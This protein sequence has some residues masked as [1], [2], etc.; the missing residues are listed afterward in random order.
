[1]SLLEKIN[2]L[3]ESIGN[4]ENPDTVKL[5][6][7]VAC[8]MTNYHLGLKNDTAKERYEK[9]CSGCEYNAEEPIKSMQVE[10]SAIPEIS[11]KICT[12]CGGCVLSYKLRQSVKKCEFW[13]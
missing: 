11:N 13:K 4:E 12:H 1:M 3:K 6:K 7:A 9:Y 8:G 10:D 2:R 5:L